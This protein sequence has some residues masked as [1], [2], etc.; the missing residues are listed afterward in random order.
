MHVAILAADR[1]HAVEVAG[2]QDA[3]NEARL[4]SRDDGLYQLSIV[5]EGAAPL[6]CSSGLRL[7]PDATLDE[8]PEPLDTLIVVGSSGVPRPSAE[9]TDWIRRRAPSTRRYGSVCTGAF[10][11]GS[12]GL[13]DGRRVTTHWQHVSELAAA[14]PAANVEGDR[15]FLRDGPLFTSA[16]ES[17]AIDMALSLIEEDCGRE[18]AL[19]VARRLV[20]FVKRPGGQSQLSVQLAAQVASST[21][22][23]EAQTFARDHPTLDL[24]VGGLAHHAGMS[25]RNFSR[26]FHE[27]AGMTPAE[28]VEVTRVEA[29]RRLLEDTELSMQRVARASGFTGSRALRRI[30]LRRLEMT[31]A[32]YRARLRSPQSG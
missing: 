10:L 18:L 14:F 12:A 5:A 11:F 1:A 30:F 20:L 6:R 8:T 15:I 23:L 26:V 27:E 32:Q 28:F 31:P 7:L 17:S 4:C 29:A 19:A 13:L 22:I 9:L 24:S 21:P 16:G 25:E 3:F 2:L